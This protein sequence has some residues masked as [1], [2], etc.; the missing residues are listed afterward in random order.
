MSKIENILSKSITSELSNE[1]QN[2]LESWI[3]E[4]EHNTKEYEAYVQLWEKSKE[5]VYSDSIDV[6]D[7]LHKTKAKI[8]GFK[9]SW[10][11]ATLIRQAA[12]VLLLSLSLSVLFHYI[13]TNEKDSAQNEQPIYQEI[14]AA[15]GTKT[16]VTLA[17]GTS[18]WLNSGS[19]LRFPSTFKNCNRREVELRG[20]GFFDVEKNQKK[21][22]IVNTHMLDVKVYGTSFNVC[23]Y[24]DYSNMTVALVEGKISLMKQSVGENKE[25]IALNPDEVV[26]YDAYNRKLYHSSDN[27]MDKYTAWKEGQIIFYNDPIE[28]VAQTLEKWYNVEINIVDPSLHSYCFTAKFLDESLEHVLKL[29]CLSSPMKYEII[30][31]QKRSDH[32]FSKRKINLSIK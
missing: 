21:P 8:S 17:D 20:E 30:P 13:S 29:L 2:I 1:E 24:E 6:D 32:S 16:K 18:V 5:L 19:I 27:Y 3:A 7:S 23:A 25:L 4:S 28:R 11:F 26:E 15:Y 10:N 9:R 31:S 12:A 14:T 22:F